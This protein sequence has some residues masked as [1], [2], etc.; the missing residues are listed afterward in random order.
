MLPEKTDRCLGDRKGVGRI[1][2]EFGKSGGVGFSAGIKDV[3]GRIGD[4]SRFNHIDGCGVHHHCRVNSGERSAFEQSYLSAVVPDFL[5]G[6]AEHAHR[7]TAIVGD[8]RRCN[9]GSHGDRGDHVVSAS[10][11]DSWKGVILG[12]DGQVERSRTRPRDEGGR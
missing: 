1:D 11:T 6:R 7:E 9:C 10:V 5:G 4:H 12:A 8:L 2:P 3:E